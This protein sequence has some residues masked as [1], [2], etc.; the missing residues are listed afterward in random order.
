MK[1]SQGEKKNWRGF[2][3]VDF[4]WGGEEIGVPTNADSITKTRKENPKVPR[5]GRGLGK[6]NEKRALT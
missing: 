1:N 2:P 3:A 6:R 5:L 4:G